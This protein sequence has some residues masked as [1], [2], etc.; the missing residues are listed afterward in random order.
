MDII[1][2]KDLLQNKK[3]FKYLGN[4]NNVILF[5]DNVY[6][7]IANMEL[8][9][10]SVNKVNLEEKLKVKINDSDIIKPN[11]LIYDENNRFC[12]YSMPYVK[13]KTIREYD[14][15]LSL[16]S[17][18]N[19]YEYANL[20]KKLEDIV[21]RNSNIVIPDLLTDG[22]FL[23]TDNLDIKLVDTDSMQIGK[24]R[25]FTVSTALGIDDYNFYNY[26]KYFDNKTKLYKKALDIRSLTIHYFLSVFNL[27]I[28]NME[29]NP[30]NIYTL[31]KHIN[32]PDQQIFYKVAS[33]FIDKDEFP[34]EYLGDDVFKIAN[35][36]NLVIN[37]YQD[38]Y[39]I[40]TLVKKK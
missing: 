19:L 9:T 14:D 12:G 39:P 2:K 21:R 24:N 1:Y 28:S 30:Q 34:N 33:L 3:D 5:K 31:F 15:S 18:T 22:N 38:N 23:I 6:K 27:D 8:F 32:L 7:F 29:Q 20:Y 25:T 37:S 26:H 11:G 17:K 35:Q 4:K 40:K 16:S 10:Y 36:Y 13:G